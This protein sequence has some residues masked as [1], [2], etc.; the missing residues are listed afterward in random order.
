MGEFAWMGVVLGFGEIEGVSAEGG[1]L[2][3]GV[4]QR[5]L[6]CWLGGFGF[7]GRVVLF[8]SLQV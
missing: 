5:L 4:V 1:E 6:G 3:L 8:G 2:E 7:H